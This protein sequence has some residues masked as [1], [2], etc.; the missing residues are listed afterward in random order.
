MLVKRKK[1]KHERKPKDFPVDCAHFAFFGSCK[2]AKK[3]LGCYYNPNR[4]EAMQKTN[5]EDEPK[6]SS[7]WFYSSKRHSTNMLNMLE[8]IKSGKGLFKNGNR[9]YF[10]YQRRDKNEEE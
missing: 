3:C 5:P 7:Q 6:R 8:D 1:N 10:R 4:I 2:T 9:C